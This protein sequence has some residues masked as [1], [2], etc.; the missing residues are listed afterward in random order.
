[1]S[2]V[3]DIKAAADGS[4]AINAFP[5]ISGE[6]QTKNRMMVMPAYISSGTIA[7]DTAVVTGSGYLHTITFSQNDA[8]PTAGS[9]IIYDNTAESGTVLFSSTWT[10]AVFSPVTVTLD[11]P[12][13]TGIY[14]GFT[15]TAD[16]NVVIS[17]I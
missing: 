5:L 7:A 16:I 17:Y 3:G 11:I 4:I 12:Y 10:T 15:T 2:I 13:A 1:M 14:A 6:N 9:I 8:A